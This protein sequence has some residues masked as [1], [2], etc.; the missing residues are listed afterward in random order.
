MGAPREHRQTV[1]ALSASPPS[2]WLSGPQA[3]GCG[4][5]RRAGVGRRVTGPHARMSLPPWPVGGCRPTRGGDPRLCRW[6]A[7][8][9]SHAGGPRARAAAGMPWWRVPGGPPCGVSPG[10][11]RQRRGTPAH[12]LGCPQ[13]PS[14]GGPLQAWRPRRRHP[15][16]PAVGGRVPPAARH[17]VWVV[18]QRGAPPRTANV[19]PAGDRRA[20]EVAVPCRGAGRRGPPRRRRP[21]ATPAWT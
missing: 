7:C 18:A 6:P 5:S 9:V 16:G 12:G 1:G 10:G 8:G 13:C 19:R 3:V 11:A 21:W 4:A 2:A 15:C 14:G 20:R 17:A